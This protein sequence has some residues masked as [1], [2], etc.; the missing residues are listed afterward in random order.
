MALCGM[1]R[2]GPSLF[3]QTTAC[4]NSHLMVQ[5]LFFAT[6][7]NPVRTNR[8]NRGALCPSHSG[9]ELTKTVAGPLVAEYEDRHRADTRRIAIADPAQIQL[10]GRKCGSTLRN[11]MVLERQFIEWQYALPPGPPV[12]FVQT[13]DNHHGPALHPVFPE[14]TLTFDRFVLPL[15]RSMIVVIDL[16]NLKQRSRR[17][18]SSGA[19]LCRRCWQSARVFM[20]EPFS[21]PSEAHQTMRR[22]SV[23]GRQMRSQ[24]SVLSMSYGNWAFLARDFGNRKR[25][26]VWCDL[27]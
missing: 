4:T 25:V 13:S 18:L 23:C 1:A 3:R 10:R 14:Q 8:F 20:F 2:D 19:E 9:N 15:F 24:G 5:A 22:P 16:E 12:G 17:R 26:R 11:P 6:R 21:Q 27:D 7:P